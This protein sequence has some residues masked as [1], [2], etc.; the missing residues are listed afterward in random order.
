MS[1]LFFAS[2]ELLPAVPKGK[3]VLI[4]GRYYNDGTRGIGIVAVVTTGVDWA[5]YIGSA[6]PW[7]ER[8]AYK[9]AAERGCKLTESDARH[10]FPDIKLRYR[11]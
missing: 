6:D 4:R 1:E 5:A 10:I 7:R 9:E 3:E 11:Q 2:Q 8:D